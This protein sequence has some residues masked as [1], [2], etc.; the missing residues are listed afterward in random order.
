VFTSATSVH[1]VPSHVSTWSLSPDCN[2]Q[3]SKP[4]VE[5][6]QPDTLYLAVFASFTSL[7]E[8]PF[9]NSVVAVAA[10]AGLR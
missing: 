5:L 3:A 6:P 4:A 7:Q 8:V 1:E 9:H 2:P 10:L